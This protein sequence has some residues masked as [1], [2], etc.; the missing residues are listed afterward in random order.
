MRVVILY[1]TSWY[2]Y[3]L[4]RNLIA[5]L[6][7]AGCEVIVV[8]PRDSYTERLINLGV[9]HVSIPLEPG[10]ANPL[11]ELHTFKAIRRAL[12][13]LRP[14]AVLSFTIKCNLY[15][16]FCKRF[17]PFVQVANI[18][19][20]GLA[21]ERAGLMR[22][23]AKSLYKLALKRTD[24]IFFQNHEDLQNCSRAK[25][26]AL[27]RSR[28]IP[29]SGVDLSAFLPTPRKPGR[30][31]TF[32]MFGR[33]L[34]QKGYDLYLAA[35]KR[36]RAEL[37][38]GVACWILGSADQGR[39]DSVELLSRIH[40]AHDHGYIRYLQSSDDVRPF[41]NES[42]IVV[43]PSTYNEG[44][45]RSLLESMASA[46]AIITTDWKGCR[47]T[48]VHGRN[49]HLIPPHDGESLYQSMRHMALCSESELASFGRESRKRS[50]EQFD[51]KIVLEAYAN[52]LSLPLSTTSAL[53]DKSKQ[54]L[55]RSAP[56]KALA[57]LE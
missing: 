29:G 6:R 24:H 34:P 2:V 32:L 42:D 51:E 13:L 16:G 28:V 35:A 11:T 7:E 39:P 17:T 22:T 54:E 26:V 40:K 15:A 23:V 18:S 25:L 14:D 10:S 47:E 33:L 31:R 43:L 5:T 48:V 4:R 27:N 20:L 30:P 49:G 41:L 12:K 44:V 45:P 3:L 9:R 8:A 37:G 38:V 46:K 36:L 21:F 53:H 19:G 52:A 56:S 57:P 1:N 50:E 55:T